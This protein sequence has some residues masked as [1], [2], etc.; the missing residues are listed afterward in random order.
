MGDGQE[1][2]WYAGELARISQIDFSGVPFGREDFRKVA[3]GYLQYEIIKKD[4]KTPFPKQ[5]EWAKVM[6]EVV[7]KWPAERVLERMRVAVAVLSNGFGTHL[8][9]LP[10]ARGK[11][12][13]EEDTRPA[14]NFPRWMVDP[15][16][17]AVAK[18]VDRMHEITWAKLLPTAREI[19]APS[20]P[21]PAADR[22]DAARGQVVSA[23][24]AQLDRA[25]AAASADLARHWARAP[26]SLVCAPDLI[27]D[28]DD[29]EPAPA[30]PAKAKVPAEAQK[31]FENVL[32]QLVRIDRSGVPA[33]RDDVRDRMQ[34]CLLYGVIKTSE[35]VAFPERA[36]W[37]EIMPAVLTEWP[38][39]KIYAQMLSAVAKVTD[40][41]SA[42]FTCLPLIS[43]RHPSYRKRPI[44][45][46]PRWLCQ[47][48]HMGS[49]AEFFDRWH[50][51]VW[52][53]LLPTAREVGSPL[54]PLSAMESWD[55]AR[56]Q[57]IE[58][59]QARLDQAVRDASAD[60]SQYWAPD[61]K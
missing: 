33:G 20:A 49:V 54:T 43:N 2:Q 60:L 27:L 9:R 41:I 45:D 30:A 23:C 31:W 40:T 6:A 10:L 36:R 34:E 42:R 38:Q 15:G 57:A 8:T 18:F 19:A 28:M 21:A 12:R 52:A 37:K 13:L 26:K 25:I 1:A 61:R 48:D 50:E 56:R 53:Q 4:D 29:K 51:N 46:F 32:K 11:H 24:Q 5:A 16:L 7:A 3:Q 35:S 17:E 22:W 47:S 59:C 55:T 39:H 14:E 58:I 44:V